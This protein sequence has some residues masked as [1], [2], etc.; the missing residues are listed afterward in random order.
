MVFTQFRGTLGFKYAVK[1]D[2]LCYMSNSKHWETWNREQNEKT[3]GKYCGHKD[4]VILS[5]EFPD[6][7][8]GK[9]DVIC[10]SCGVTAEWDGKDYNQK[11]PRRVFRREADNNND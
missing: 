2:T 10:S 1:Y 6:N 3:Y 5:R 9:F 7:P 4:R 11:L 8:T